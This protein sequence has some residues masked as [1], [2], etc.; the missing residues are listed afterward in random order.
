MS[1]IIDHPLFKK[2]FPLVIAAIVLGGI[3]FSVV[4]SDNDGT[5]D[6]VTIHIGGTDRAGNPK[7]VVVTADTDQELQP[8]QVEEDKVSAPESGEK[9]SIAAPADIDLHEDMKDETPPGV[10]P[11]VIEA[12]AEKTEE[13]A[14]ETLDTPI[15]P[16]GAQ[17]YSCP[18][19]FVV[20]QS[21]LS[22]PRVG[23]ALHFTVSDPGSINAIWRLFNTPAFGASS[24]FGIELSGE[25]QTWVPRNRKAWAQGAANSA[26]FSIEIVTKDLTATQW[27]N[28]PIIKNGILAG[29][30][31]DLNRSVGAP[32]RKVDPVGCAWTPGIVDH[33]S[34]ECGNTHWD[35][36]RN[37]PW[38]LFIRQ[39]NRG[40]KPTC[41]TNCKALKKR[42]ARVHVTI[43]KERCRPLGK[44]KREICRT[45]RMKE[46]VQHQKAY[47]NWKVKL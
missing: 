27:R 47:K 3:A 31:R 21:P 38:P 41:G 46:Q 37:F 7:P 19:H 34:L 28:A 18:N 45:A 9:P 22:G 23:T 44:T 32:L 15:A 13:L 8:A 2:Y 40:V 29:L 11:E 42:H 33:D 12:G 14:D 36:G 17:A 26:Y 10:D 5:P 30:V 25:C 4:D 6:T 43:Q 24:N 35:V 20:N 39:V 1:R 16:A